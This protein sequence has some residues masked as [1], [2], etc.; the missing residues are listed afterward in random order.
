MLLLSLTS[1]PVFHACTKHI[2]LDVHFV[3]NPVFENKL[4]VRYIPTEAQPTDILTKA[5]SF[6]RFC[7]LCTKLGMAISPVA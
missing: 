4:E 7:T 6:D 3:H 2:E 5:L 1:N